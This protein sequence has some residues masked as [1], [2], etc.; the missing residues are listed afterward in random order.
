MPKLVVGETYV[1]EEGMSVCM[2]NKS[3]NPTY[4]FKGDN[5]RLYTVN[6]I[7]MLESKWNIKEND[8]A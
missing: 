1:D 5:G 2:I 7:N 4:C 8:D 3:P 6:G